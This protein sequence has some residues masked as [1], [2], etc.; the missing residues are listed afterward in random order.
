MLDDLDH[1]EAYY[2]DKLWSLIPAVY[3]A[4]D[5]DQF[6]AKGPLRELVNRI[7][8]QAAILR[9]SIDRLWEDQSIETCD[10]WVIPYIAD[11][12]ATN[13][14]NGLDARGQRI[15][16]AKTIYF[17]RRKGTLAILEEI[18]ADITGWDARVVEFF[19]RLGRT[20][21]NLDPAIEVPAET[22]SR[23][24]HMFATGDGSTTVFNFTP[25]PTPV[26]PG[27]VQVFLSGKQIGADN[28]RGVIAGSGL[29]TNTANTPN[30]V[31]Y[32]TG[33]TNLTFTAAPP[34]GATVA[35]FYEYPVGGDRSVQLAEGL[36]GALTNSFI[37]G[38]ADL[39][40]VYG[41]ALADPELAA[42]VHL[43]GYPHKAFDEFYHT[44]DFRR[45]AGQAGWHN[46]PRLGVFLW[47]LRSFG[48]GQTTP[49]ES[50]QCPGQFTFD[51]TGREIPLF[52]VSARGQGYNWDNWTS[53]AEWQLP[54]PI[55][56]PMLAPALAQNP[57]Y[58]LYS[59]IDPLDG[60]IIPNAMGVFQENT[61]GFDLVL[62]SQLT[63]D[64]KTPSATAQILATGDG[65]TIA[66]SFTLAP[67]PVEPGTIQVFLAGAPRGADNDRGVIAGSGV[68]G[69]VNYATGATTLTFTNAPVAG[70]TIAIFYDYPAVQ[71]AFYIDPPRGR[72]VTR[73]P[74]SKG[75]LRA[76]YHYGFP[77]TI[78]AGP[79]D[80]RV[81]GYTPAHTAA[82]V[83]GGNGN[84]ATALSAL[85]PSGV[86][87]IGDFLTYDSVSNVGSAASGIV[88]VTVGAENEMR[89]LICLPA[90][91]SPNVTEWVFTGGADAT[92]L[93]KLVLDGLFVSGGDI[94]LKGFFD[95]VSL[96]CTTLDPGNVGAKPASYAKAVDGRDLI[97]CH[98]WVEGSVKSLTIDRSVVGPVRTRAAGKIG[99]QI[100]TL[101]LTNSIVQAVGVAS[102]QQV[103]ATG[104]G[105]KTSFDSTLAPI[106][107]DPGTVRIVVT[108][109]QAGAD[110]GS[111]AIIGGGLAGTVD[112][113]TGAMTLTFTT[114]PAAGATVMAVYY[115]DQLAIE[116]STGLAIISRC[117][118]LG[119]ASLHRIEASECILDDIVA[120]INSQDG[121]VRFSAY[122]SGGILPR[123]YESV[124]VA[125]RA[126]L[127]TSR[128]FGQP[129][130]AQLLASV[131]SAIITGARNATI[132][133]GAEDGSE[134]GAYARDNNPIKE[135][136]ILIKYQEY[137]PLGLVPVIIDVT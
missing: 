118:I 66:F 115:E 122:A 117:T 81:N 68:T 132:S 61:S 105:T 56:R 38:W 86:V 108:G 76:T 109:V 74:T 89:P 84:L 87:T 31:N 71:A 77:S 110:N 5:T 7:G 106:P 112:Y 54:T 96:I 9:R 93:A 21:H 51:P 63:A 73:S 95:T 102:E 39:R 55:T 43:A 2:A 98:L 131:D 46:I 85:G 119:P 17:R 67:T 116:M 126:P 60:S 113:A 22:S 26:E 47:R 10:D 103:L 3:R 79:Y 53:P 52:A 48:V 1:Y 42:T 90:M 128:E 16:V 70:A 78:G 136:S 24:T 129:A 6:D 101:T 137:M 44:A 29:T 120:V 100:E 75:A 107:V 20:R 15:D 59:S 41:A 114:A 18:A 11:L 127:F 124:E 36:V 19:R 35:V 14:V 13:L 45:G 83:T 133:M 34:P 111:G 4:E 64:P 50:K 92:N 23:T 130:Y 32:A 72:L 82:P 37:G 27:T 12:L 123:Q 99:P 57:A 121:C 80:R 33:A 134:M 94:V 88:D 65:R 40:N 58:P 91:P 8:V 69:T 97:P 104:D 30:T 135:R 28:A 62:A 25:T 125:P 49:V